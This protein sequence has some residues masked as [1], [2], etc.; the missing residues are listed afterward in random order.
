MTILSRGCKSLDTASSQGTK[1][2]V[3]DSVYCEK[4][5]LPDFSMEA[6]SKHSILC[7]LGQELPYNPGDT[8]II[9]APCKGYGVK[10][11]AF[12]GMHMALIFSADMWE[13]AIAL[14][15]ES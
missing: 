7:E 13:D 11:S 15:Q 14:F 2:M 8:I 6:F 3:S 1:M 9:Q 4:D 5:G 12:V 10:C